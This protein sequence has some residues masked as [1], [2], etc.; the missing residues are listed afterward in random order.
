LW[1]FGEKGKDKGKCK[2]KSKCKG[3]SK[4]RSFA[5]LRMTKL[6]FTPMETR[7]VSTAWF[8]NDL[9]AVFGAEGDFGL[10]GYGVIFYYFEAPALG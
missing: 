3:K 6:V 4:S 8:G 10:Q 1:G 2:D 9:D 5:L 7:L